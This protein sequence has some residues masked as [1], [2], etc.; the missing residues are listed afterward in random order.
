M[1]CKRLRLDMIQLSFWVA[2]LAAL[3]AAAT[4]VSKY[5]VYNLLTLPLVAGGLLYH[6][7]APMGS[8]LAYSAGGIGSGFCLLILPYALGGLGAG[9]VK[10]LAG[11][12]A[13]VGPDVILPILLVACFATGVYSAILIVQLRGLKGIV[14][15]IR[16]LLHSLVAHVSGSA[17]S[18]TG[19]Q[20]IARESDRRDR[21]V[22]FSAMLAIGV[23]CVFATDWYSGW[24]AF[25]N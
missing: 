11:I 23:W 13:W 12:G 24:I 19:V 15:N 6:S 16:F 20:A 1:P 9:D 7:L 5:K 25:G 8:G 2:S 17:P 21:L 10:F 3:I 14:H 22:P 18:T 4:D